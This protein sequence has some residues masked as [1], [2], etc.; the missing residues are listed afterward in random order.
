MSER[1]NIE[2]IVG[3]AIR[4]RRL[5]ALLAELYAQ[6]GREI[7][8]AAE[9]QG[10]GLTTGPP[11]LS[12]V[13]V[14]ELLAELCAR[15]GR[16]TVDAAAST[17]LPVETHVATWRAQGAEVAGHV[18]GGSGGPGADEEVEAAPRGAEWVRA[19]IE[20]ALHQRPGA[21]LVARLG[22]IGLD[23]Q[24]LGCALVEVRL[25]S[26]DGWVRLVF[27]RG[28]WSALDGHGVRREGRE[29]VA[30]LLAQG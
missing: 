13:D 22:E 14:R 28:Q 25:P 30:A 6:I 16:E 12:L 21:G 24:D 27:E 4:A 7:V 3:R 2:E 18:V 15:P 8:D 17:G 10:L 5:R 20:Q 9:A 23:A 1:V 11:D 26:I 29:A 19:Q